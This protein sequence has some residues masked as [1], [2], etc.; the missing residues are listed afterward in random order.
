[1][2]II[3]PIADLKN[4]NEFSELCHAQNEPIFLTKN[5]Y[6]DLV[7]MSLEMYEEMEAK[8][9]A[10]EAGEVEEKKKEK[11]P[12]PFDYRIPSATRQKK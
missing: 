4:Y 12:H 9:K 11:K 2:P 7:V 8:I 6:G 5:G 3:K 1:M 10:I